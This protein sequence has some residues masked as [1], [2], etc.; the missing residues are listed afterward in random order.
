[1]ASENKG[2]LYKPAI[3]GMMGE[4]AYYVS[5]MSYAQI[6]HYVKKPDEIYISKKLSD[7][8]QRKLSNRYQDIL[9]YLKAEPERF[10]NS[11]V[12]AVYKGETKWH[13]YEFNEKDNVFRTV[14]LLE[15]DGDELIFPIDGQH[16]VEAIKK[17]VND[18]TYEDDEEVPVIYISHDPDNL[19]RTR[20]L[21]TTLNRYAK[22]VGDSDIIALDEDDIVA[23]A[24]RYQVEKFELLKDK[25]KCKTEE[26]MD[27]DNSEYLS[28]V[29][30]YKCNELLLKGFLKDQNIKDKEK[31]YRRFRKDEKE[32]EKFYEYVCVFWES[33]IKMNKDVYEYFYENK[34]ENARS[35]NGGNLLFRPYAVKAY[36]S[37]LVALKV[38]H[39]VEY[40]EAM[41][42]L[43]RFSFDL[44][45]STWNKGIMWNSSMVTGR[46][47]LIKNVFILL[48][49]ESFITEKTRKNIIDK[50]VSIQ[51][52]EK[53]DVISRIFQ[54]GN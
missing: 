48:Y 38:G 29:T 54:K 50:Y 1:M 6:E 24:T 4:W 27:N 34:K 20:R 32:I 12:L 53:E 10:F 52:V 35:E 14:G 39:K 3:K 40:N 49:E 17:M 26:N 28:I 46:S 21:F 13:S 23:I 44:N 51:E 9:N 43:S 5:T 15:F 30:L 16:R 45:A 41:A 47:S 19:E 2:V 18:G 8:I 37:A 25:I 7:M 36:V 22:P 33:L 11:I 31:D 42:K